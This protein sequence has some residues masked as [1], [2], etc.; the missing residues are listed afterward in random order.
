MTISF[1][2]TEM[3]RGREPPPQQYNSNTCFCGICGQRFQSRSA[4]I[5]HMNTRHATNTQ[6]AESVRCTHARYERQRRYQRE[7]S[8][9]TNLRRSGSPAGHG[10]TTTSPH[11][12]RS[13]TR[14]PTRRE[15][16]P[17]RPVSTSHRSRSPRR[18]R[19]TTPATTSLI[20]TQPPAMLPPPAAPPPR[21]PGKQIPAPTTPDSSE[22]SSSSDDEHSATI[23]TVFQSLSSDSDHE[24]FSVK[25]ATQLCLKVPALPLHKIWAAS[26]RTVLPPSPKTAKKFRTS[27]SMIKSAQQF[28]LKKVQKTVNKLVN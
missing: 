7:R 6:R 27:V 28:A 17:H 8:T 12:Y 2:F 24:Q 23:N 21:F 3:D 26:T 9:I 15:C 4:R 14:S 1:H 13:P 19:S 18:S 16:S 10:P 5:Y 25:K 22:S 11:H 20:S